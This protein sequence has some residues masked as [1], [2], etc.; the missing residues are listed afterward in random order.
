MDKAVLILGSKSKVKVLRY[1]VAVGEDNV[2]SIAK[3]TGLNSAVLNRII[4]D[5]KMA[6]IVEEKRFGSGRI[7][8]LRLSRGPVAEA[9]RSLFKAIE[10]SS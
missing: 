2:T 10:E 7:R 3:N 4:N 8:I 6:G 1:L 5:F 9:L